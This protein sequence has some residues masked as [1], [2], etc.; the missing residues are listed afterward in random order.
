MTWF[1]LLSIVFATAIC[2]E[3]QEDQAESDAVVLGLAK[4]TNSDGENLGSLL[5]VRLPVPEGLVWNTPKEL[6]ADMSRGA[7]RRD[8]WVYANTLLRIEGKTLKSIGPKRLVWEGDFA[9]AINSPY[10]HYV[11]SFKIPPG[12]KISGVPIQFYEPSDRRH[13][14][15]ANQLANRTV[16]AKL[17]IEQE[18]LK[19]MAF[20]PNAEI[21]SVSPL[22]DRSDRFYVELTTNLIKNNGEF[23]PPKWIRQIRIGS[24]VSN[25]DE[26][27]IEISGFGNRLSN[28]VVGFEFSKQP[29]IGIDI[30]FKIDGIDEWVS[31]RTSW[32]KM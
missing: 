17:N 23:L 32:P 12:T 7:P 6:W 27:Y 13:D 21:K 18:A 11:H 22:P 8:I 10:K 19:K 31:C 5:S 25:P 26:R 29:P 30:Q 2:D 14:D 4:L 9:D 3:I 1:P 15:K 28:D 24:S 16:L 20:Q